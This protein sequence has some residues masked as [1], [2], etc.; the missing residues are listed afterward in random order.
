[1]LPATVCCMPPFQ[2]RV[3]A[4]RP[5][6]P[7]LY[8]LIRR[9]G[10]LSEPKARHYFRQ[11]ISGVEY[12]HRQASIDKPP[13]PER[14]MASGSLL[15]SW[16]GSFSPASHTRMNTSALLQSRAPLPAMSVLPWQ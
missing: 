13:K 6:P 9:S 16:L 14:G 12:C 5:L 15:F 3:M 2:A 4:V 7:Q 1:M 8:D 11:L 10:K